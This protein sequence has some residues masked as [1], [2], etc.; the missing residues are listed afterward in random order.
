MED[1]SIL[2]LIKKPI[3]TLSKMAKEAE[4]KNYS[5]LSKEELSFQL[6][7]NLA[8]ARN[9][10]FAG[11]ILEIL[12]EGY[13]FLRTN[14]YLLDQKDIY[15][16]PSQIRKF[17]LRTGDMVVGYTRPPRENENYQALLKI[18]AVNYEDPELAA[19]RPVFEKLI[20]LYPMEKI[21]LERSDGDISMRIIDLLIPIGKGQRGLI[22]SPPKAGKTTLLKKI[23]NSITENHP[24]I[25]I[26]VLLIDERPEEVTDIERS[27]KGEVIS[28][29]FDKKIS[30][31]LQVTEMVLEKAKRRV[32]QGKDVIILLDS[33]TRLSRAYNIDTP[34]TGQTLT[35]G[36]NPQ[37]L[38]KP[39]KFFGAARKIEN[40]GSLTILAT[41][42]IDT[43]SRMDEIIFEEFK[44]TGNCEM[45]LD[46][47]LFNRRIFPALDI[48]KSSTRKEELLVSKPVLN[49]MHIL[50]KIFSTLSN[51]EAISLLIERMKKTKNNKEFLMTISSSC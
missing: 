35:G 5:N 37:A 27:V 8:R 21:N 49:K 24:E 4:V 19:Q 10:H 12:S 38:Y 23:A 33:L 16:S 42:L 25:E 15:V 3:K 41:A 43:G 17:G 30:H 2:E 6:M 50:R 26:T 20:P 45:V 47:E 34:S 40:G 39:K 28:S 14:S 36:V 22:V 48:K 1:I 7:Q 11:G 13:G 9:Q 44:G 18:D 32:E 51:V 46:R 29:T 31:H